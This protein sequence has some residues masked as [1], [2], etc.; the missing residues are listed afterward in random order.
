GRDDEVADLATV[1]RH[2]MSEPQLTA[3][4]PVPQAT[5]PVEIG[6]LVTVRVPAHLPRFRSR[7]RFVAHRLHSQPPLL[8]DQGLD[9]E[10]TA[11]TVPHLVRV[12]L[13]LDQ[14]SLRPQ[15]FDDPLSRLERGQ[16]VVWK[17]RHI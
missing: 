2:T 16:T 13:F 5:Q 6:A 1:D 17:A 9:H 12:R 3:D 11:V 8:A 4:V 15:V 7:K 14:E 10:V